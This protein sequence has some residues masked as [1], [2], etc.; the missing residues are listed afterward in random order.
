VH[1]VSVK[2]FYIAKY[3]LTVKE[4]KQFI[5]DASASY[6]SGKRDHKMPDEPNADW[7]AEHPDTKKFYPLPTHPWWGWVD[8]MPMQRIS[9]YDAVAYCNWLSDKE[10]LQKCYVEN[11]D[12]GI[13]LDRTKNGYRLP[14]EAEW[15][16]AARGG[17]KSKNTIFAGSAN[18]ADV[19]WYDDTSQLKGPQKVGSKKPNELGIYDMSGNV[20][21]WCSDYYDKAYYTKSPQADPFN[22]VPSSYRVLRGGSWHY[23]VEHATVT[24]RDGPEPAFTNFNYGIRLARN[25][26]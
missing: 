6:F 11:E 12:G 9:W 13:D 15:E 8:D 1:A 24:S 23:Q 17:N 10:G 21:E 20:W 22:S 14:T 3:E 26:Q 25:A 7:Y 2:S 16:F 4:Y 19:C 18:A 5:N